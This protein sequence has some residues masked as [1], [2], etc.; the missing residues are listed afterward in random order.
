[1]GVNC[2]ALLRI[3]AELGKLGTYYLDI[4]QQLVLRSLSPQSN[5]AVRHTS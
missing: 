3:R 5:K 2:K 4:T 1:M